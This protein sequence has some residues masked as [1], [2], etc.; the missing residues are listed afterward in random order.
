MDEVKRYY[1]AVII[2]HPDATVDEQKELFRKNK[3]TIESFKG[4]IHSLDTWGKRT[5]GTP[6]GKI[7][8]AVYFHT[9]FQA[10]TQA[11]MEL[12][13]TMRINDKV[14]RFMHTRLDERE[15][16]SKHYENFKASLTESSQR[17]RERETKMQ[18]K[19]QMQS[20]SSQQ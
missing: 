17:E 18:M 7:R 15:S 20:Q 4:T 9:L 13:R 2:V 3:T 6:I 14:L 1:E 8:K 10:G 12:E 5:M 16:L 19:R 11:I